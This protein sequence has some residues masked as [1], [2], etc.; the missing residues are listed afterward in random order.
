LHA[1][2]APR[3]DSIERIEIETQEAGVRII[4]KTGP[5]ANPRTAI[6]VSSTWSPCR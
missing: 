1:E 5:L 2:V 3:F 6:T 4:D